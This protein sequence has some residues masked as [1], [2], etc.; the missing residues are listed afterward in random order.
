MQRQLAKQREKII[1]PHARIS[2]IKRERGEPSRG[3]TTV[4]NEL[5]ASE[6]KRQRITQAAANFVKNAAITVKVHAVQITN[7]KRR[8]FLRSAKQAN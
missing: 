7:A 6:Y 5:N 4:Q 1:R 3:S 2:G 8:K